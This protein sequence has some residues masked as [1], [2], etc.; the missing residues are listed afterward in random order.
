MQANENVLAGNAPDLTDAERAA[1]EGFDENGNPTPPAETPPPAAP[2]A[3]TEAA[4]VVPP[5]PATDTP[6]PA[7]AP[8]AP[9]VATE[10]APTPAATPQPSAPATGPVFTPSITP[11]TARDYAAEIKALKTQYEAGEI[12]DDKYEEDRE[13]I[14]EARTIHN[15][16]SRIAEQLAE[17]GWK[18]NVSSFLQLP[19]NAALLRSPEMKD[20]WQSMMNRTVTE[21]AAAGKQ[22]SDWEILSLGRDKLFQTLGISANA[23]PVPPPVKPPETPAKPNQAPNLTNVPPTL[24]R[25]PSAAPTGAKTTAESLA[26]ADNIFDI[27]AHMATLSE[28]QADEMLRTLPGAFA[29]G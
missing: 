3:T 6:P 4:A 11:G 10:T 5:P 12:D 18:A 28:A 2:P 27:E 29:G 8:T 14:V 24:A 17:Q 7:A 21:A 25:A 15:S 22:L 9:V 20:L 13:A 26:A 1:M 23:D 16:E 19:D